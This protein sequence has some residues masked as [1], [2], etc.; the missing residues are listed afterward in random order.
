MKHSL[1][2][3]FSVFFWSTIEILVWGI[4]TVYLDRVGGAEFNFVTVL[5]GALILWHFFMRAQQNVA[6]GFLEDVWTRN[7][8]NLLASP[9]TTAEFLAGFTITSFALTA[10]TIVFVGTLAWLLFA[11][12]ILSFG[13]ML[14][15][16]VAILLV[17]GWALGFVTLA[18]LI[19]YGP[20]AE[21][22]AW[23][24]VSFVQPVA[25]VFYPVSVLPAFLQPIAYALPIT[26]VFEG[27]RAI[28]L[29]EQFASANLVYAFILTIAYTAASVWLFVVAFRIAKRE[30]YLTHFSTESF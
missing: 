24:I 17:F 13:V 14:L 10:T 26:H 3:I 2:R 28:I 7:L 18:I 16:F 11:F 22:I 4:L 1:G 27:M 12:N 21:V 23:S 15:P 5:L 30:G 19:R 9:I 29:G 6:F 20:A 8:P 25:A